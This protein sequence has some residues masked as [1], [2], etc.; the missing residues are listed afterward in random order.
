MV[1]DKELDISDWMKDN[2]KTYLEKCKASIVY[3]DVNTHLTVKQ[4]KLGISNYVSAK[5][6]SDQKVYE[7]DN[8][9]NRDKKYDKGN[10][11]GLSKKVIYFIKD[12]ECR[13]ILKFGGKITEMEKT[14]KNHSKP[15]ENKVDSYTD[16]IDIEFEFL[17]KVSSEE[18]YN[19][20]TQPEYIEKWVMEG[21]SDGEKI[22]IDEYEF[23]FIN[24]KKNHVEIKFM[25]NSIVTI[26]FHGVNHETRIKIRQT[27]VLVSFKDSVKNFWIHRVFKTIFMLFGGVIIN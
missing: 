5:W 23:S 9:T 26:T 8:Y 19:W 17:A 22:I 16:N 27:N 4:G 11:K 10:R 25:D 20:F 3:L 2:I 6:E 18:L 7:I 21:E 12:F 15:I 24:K 13:A 14:A 1:Y